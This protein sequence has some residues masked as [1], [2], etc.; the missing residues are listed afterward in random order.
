[1]NDERHKNKKYKRERKGPTDHRM[2][3]NWFI[4]AP[5]RE[6]RETLRVAI[7]L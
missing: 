2:H 3:L 7:W 1:M 6:K 5:L 4:K